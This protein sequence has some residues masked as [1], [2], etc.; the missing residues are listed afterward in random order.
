MK[1]KIIKILFLPILVIKSALYYFF[2]IFPYSVRRTFVQNEEI[3]K[4]DLIR[5]VVKKYDY[6]ILIETGTY[7]GS[8]TIFLSNFFSKI[9][10]VELDKD[11]F[12]KTKKKL[13]RLN[14]VEFFNDDS[15][16]FLKK[17]IPTIKEKSIFFLDAHYSGPGTS[18]LKGE[19]PC[20][21]ELKEI[22]KS[23]IKDHIIIIDDISDF[24]IS[25]NKQKLS[26][27]IDIIEK[28]SVNYKFYFEYDMMFALPNEKL[29][30]EFFKEII[31]HFIIR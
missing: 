16:S 2:K 7:L 3:V 5:R 9:L 8:T 27:I 13:E 1:T 19:T 18:N 20:I 15:E 26:E 6:K 25:A 12:L 21:K 23:D 30:R 4:A 11:L 28:I 14:N 22:S 31:S 29:H 10:T 17:I 24:S